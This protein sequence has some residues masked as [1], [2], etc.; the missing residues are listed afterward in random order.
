[1]TGENKTLNVKIVADAA[2]YKRDIQEAKAATKDFGN[3]AKTT[4]NKMEILE[5]TIQGQQARLET[6]KSKYNK[7]ISEQKGASTAAKELEAKMKLLNVQISTNQQKLDMNRQRLEAFTSAQKKTNQSINTSG[8]SASGSSAAMG[9]LASTLTNIKNLQM[10]D[11]FLTMGTALAGLK[12]QFSKAGQLF[13]Q[14]FEEI[15]GAFNF[16][17]MDVGEDG[18]K[19]IFGSMKIQ[20]G[21]ALKS[22]AGGFKTLG[23]AIKS[24]MSSAVAAIAAAIA[25]LVTFIALIKNAINT[26]NRLRTVFYEAQKIG[27]SAAAYE[28]WGYILNH[29]GVEA[30][31]LSDFIKGLSAAQNDLRDGTEA[32]VDAFEELGLSAEEAANMSQEE[33]FVETVKRLQQLENQVQKTSIAYRIFGEDDASQIANVLNLNSQQMEQMIK[34]YRLLGGEASDSAI[35][36]SLTLTAAIADMKTAW[37]GLTNTLGEEFMPMITA[38]VRWITKAIAIVNMF[39]RAILGFDIVSSGSKSTE[40]MNSYNE[41]MEGAIKTAE[42]LKRTTQGFDELNIVSNPN[43]NN[44]SDASASVNYGGGFE[45][46]DLGAKFND[47]G[48]DEFKDKIEKWKDE[49]RAIVPAAMVAV[50]AIGG[51]LA[52]LSG[53]WVLAIAL[54]ALAGLG[55]AAMGSGE[56]GFQGYIDNFVTSCNGLLVPALIAIGAVGGVIA[57]LCGNVV[58]AVGLFALAGIGVAL[59]TTDGFQGLTDGLA[60]KVLIIVS[61][62]MVVVGVVGGIIALCCGAVPVGIGLL[63]MAGIGIGAITAGGF[64]DEIGQWFMDLFTSIGKWC[65]DV[66]DGICDIFNSVGKW[67]KDVFTGAWNGI[68]D[69]WHGAGNWFSGIWDN[70][71]GAFSNVKTWFKNKFTGAWNGIKDV[72]KNVGSWFKVNVVDKI[73]K[74]FSDIGSKIG[75]AV[76]GTFSKA[77]NVVLETAVNIIN[78]FISAINLAIGLINKI[79]GVEIDKLDKL[80]VPELATGG[81]VMGDT[82]ARIGEGGKREAVLPL[83]QN[84]GWMDMLAD[85]LADRMGGNS[86]VVL[87]VGEKELGWVTINS[88]NGITKQTGGLQLQLV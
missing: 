81:I 20:G 62:C 12:G 10:T 27:L 41:A 82:L 39:I 67:F 84:T 23:S 26:A 9:E 59:T 51:V 48:L 45:L 7:L 42:K 22:L 30:N 56:G 16:K 1:M 63:A 15:G 3:E 54:F 69:A 77:V 43:V 6:L 75:D 87:Q 18:I 88:I 13:K 53:N 76:K 65:A 55:L 37:K 31:K 72:F 25:V 58:L 24:A 79:P 50:G 29:V 21:E 47:L 40:S 83:D 44:D 35:G 2:G 78:G 52:A 73:T 85:R 14:A 8:A 17:D 5:A 49:L 60:Q 68:K 86:K 19:G 66:W 32:M 11:V 64:W 33:L 46:P 80:E 57:L 61:V 36:K 34:Q 71:A 38:V 28:E 70:I 74:V 4:A